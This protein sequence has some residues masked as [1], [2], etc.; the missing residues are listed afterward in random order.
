MSLF[1]LVSYAVA[2]GLFLI[3]ALLMLTSWRGRLQGGL[4]VTAALACTLWAALNAARAAGY[5]VPIGAMM[6]S[7]FL[8]AG[9]WIVFLTALAQ[10][11]GVSRPTRV[12]ANVAWIGALAWAGTLWLRG[13]TALVSQDPGTLF[14]ALAV[15]TTVMGLVLIEQ[16]YRNAPA[17]ARW[18][19]KYLV[20]GVGGLFAFDLYLYSDAY[21]FKAVS[22][23]AWK[24]RGLVNAMMVP[25]LAIAARRNPQW[26]LELFVSRHVVFYSTS[27]TVIGAGLIVMAFGGYYIRALG[28]TWGGAAQIVFVAGAVV[29]LVILVWSGSLR[30]R[31]KVFLGKHFYENK[32]DYREEWLKLI[33]TLAEQV[34]SGDSASMAIRALSSIVGSSGGSL[35]LFDDEQQVYRCREAWQ[36]RLDDVH[37]LS[38]DDALVRFLDERHWVIEMQE[39]REHADRYGL[40]VLPDW[41]EQRANLGL[42]VPLLLGNTLTG[43]VCLQKGQRTRNLDYEDRDLLK[44]IGRQLAT[45][46]AR[47]EADR[48]LT[49]SRQ[50]EAYHRLTAFIMHDL[51]NLIAQL[52]MIVRNAEKHRHNPEFVEDMI[53][54]VANSVE[55]MNRLMEQLLLGEAAPRGGEVDLREATERAIH[56]CRGRRPAPVLDAGGEQVRVNAEAGRLVQV[57]EHLIRN[58]QDATPE[59]GTVTVS[60]RS[61]DSTGCVRVEDSGCGM[62]GEFVRE[63]LFK[64]FDSTKGTKGMGIG[65][66]QVREYVRMMGGQIQVV[67][68]LGE[69]SVFEVHLPQVIAPPSAAAAGHRAE[70]A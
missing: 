62:D 1:G 10:T 34:D 12:L 54:T 9:A 11:L 13:H 25:L 33:A 30:A 21:L 43:F 6:V 44:T 35:W 32:F 50:F 55:R 5:P 61:H 37:H 29:T 31:L 46:I 52:S 69:G 66:Y 64:P 19:L 40:L 28:G 14:I 68:A 24:A 41:I 2:A 67:S 39:L 27:L 36:E 53:D 22:G 56:R 57:L 17:E 3:F 49:E 23:D 20:L 16:I 4:L 51:K 42:L 26:S 7:E 58:A 59:D 18:A 45:H 63:R 15:A 8:R 48:R 70:V 47:H 65:A 38:R 60:I